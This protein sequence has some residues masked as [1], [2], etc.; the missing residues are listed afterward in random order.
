MKAC[1]T[2][3]IQRSKHSSLSLAK[4]LLCCKLQQQLRKQ[5]TRNKLKI[6]SYSLLLFVLSAKQESYEYHT[7]KSLKRLDKGSERLAYRLRSGRSDEKPS[8][9]RSV[10]DVLRKFR[11]S[12]SGS[13]TR[14][15]TFSYLCHTGAIRKIQQLSLQYGPLEL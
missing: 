1:C 2:L 15:K 13:A 14:V 8:H 5:A 9:P 4:I 6:F 11:I 10:Y 7:T 12:R 3:V